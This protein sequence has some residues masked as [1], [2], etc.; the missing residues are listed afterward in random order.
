MPIKTSFPKNQIIPSLKINLEEVIHTY[1]LKNISY[2]TEIINSTT[3][4]N[5][6]NLLLIFLILYYNK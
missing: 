6:K 4:S 5:S 1:E 3:R 2:I